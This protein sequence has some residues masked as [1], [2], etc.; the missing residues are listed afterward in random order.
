MVYLAMG[1]EVLGRFEPG[2]I[3]GTLANAGVKLAPFHRL[4]K[5]VSARLRKELRE[6][7]KH[8]ADGSVS[9]DPASYV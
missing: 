9:L 5:R 3:R 7:E 2:T 6:L 8:I 1:D 4:G